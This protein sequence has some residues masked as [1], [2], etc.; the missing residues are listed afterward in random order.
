MIEA[1][2]AVKKKKMGYLK[3]SKV[4]NVPKSTL[5]DYVKHKTKDI[6]ALINTKLGRKCSLGDELEEEL[7][8]YCKVMENMY[9][10][11][12]SSDIR[13][14]AFQIAVRNNI[15]HPFSLSKGAAGKKWLR[16]FLKRHPSLSLRTPESVSLA[17][18]KGFS[19]ERVNLFFDILK[20]ELEKVNFNP[21]KVFN[22][23][24]TGISVVQSRR[25]KIISVKGKKQVGSLSSQER[26]SLM[27]IVTCM[28]AAG[29]F[30]PPLIVFPRKNMKVELLDGCP[31]G[32]IASCH[33][34]GW[35]QLH[36]FTEWFH[37]FLEY[38]KPTPDN[39]IVLILDGHFSHTRNID[40][41]HLARQHG[42]IIVCLSPHTTHKLQPLD[43]AFM[44]PFKCYYSQAVESWMSE[45]PFRALTSY[46]VGELMGKAY[47]KCATL[48]IS[49]KGF[50]SCGIIPF[51]RHIF[52]DHEFLPIENDN[53]VIEEE[54]EPEGNASKTVSPF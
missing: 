32:T 33:P 44:G 6:N 52:A 46:Q 38:T 14:L 35:I 30:V 45:H 29:M 7:V 26:A 41:I 12:R 34:S 54:G 5:E 13:Q 24:E 3:A 42:V 4:Y 25:S 47:S 27:T 49:M 9:F 43:V 48:E 17:R 39:P 40:V 20:P 51:N 31:P 8:R 15:D 10:G 2:N 50:Q 1:V 19:K 16:N 18:A 21:T 28:N 23:D 11:L 36:I 37:H 53:E 22:V